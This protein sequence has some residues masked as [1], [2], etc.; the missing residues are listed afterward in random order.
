MDRA[1]IG[2]CLHANLIG[3]RRV[4]TAVRMMH[5]TRRRLSLRNGLLQSRDRQ[6]GRQR[7]VQRPAHH[8]PRKRVEDYG[9][10]DKL[11][12]QTDIGDVRYSELIHPRQFHSTGQIQIDLELVI[13]IRGHHERP[14]LHTQQVVLPHDPQHTLVIYQHPAPP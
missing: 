5:Q 14:R 7:P 6:T 12:L 4:H 13:G 11:L 1:C 10:V 3:G 2:G 9:Q 8:F